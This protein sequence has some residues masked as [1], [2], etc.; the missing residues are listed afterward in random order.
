MRARTKVTTLLS[1]SALLLVGVALSGNR[2]TCIPIE[3]T[4]P[5]TAY[6]TGAGAAFG[7]CWGPCDRELR[8]D[9]A[10]MSFLVRG[11]DNRVFL[12]LSGDLA[13]QLT[14]AG[15]ARAEDLALS[16]LEA[17]LLPR[18]G[19]PDCA[20]GGDCFVS[21]VRE[22]V[23]STHHY[24]CSMGVPDVLRP[25]HDFWQGIMDE[26]A[27][28]EESD[29]LTAPAG[30]DCVPVWE[31]RCEHGGTVYFP[32]DSFPAGD[33]C[34]TCTCNGDGRIYCTEIA[35]Q[36]ASVLTG[37]GAEAGMCWGPCRQH[38]DIEGA[39]MTFTALGW[40]DRVYLEY[41]GDLAP[42]LTALG[43]QRASEIGQALAGVTLQPVYGCPDCADGGDCHVSLLRDGA[44]S[45]HHFDCGGG[46]PD[47][48]GDAHD[49]V[50]GMMW[51]LAMCHESD[52]FTIDADFDCIPL[53]DLTL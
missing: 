7:E 16:L 41:S 10:T 44:A 14:A 53:W 33:G 24:D 35:C 11:W 42:R 46:P 30:W 19:C 45:E 29:F 18:Y 9:G 2:T 43:L 22:G 15:R 38:L 32:G 21:L 4:A 23:A 40:D 12:D 47:V 25:A 20:D 26:L 6:F 37:G 17:D 51:D 13:V 52:L 49:F 3:P 34:N 5:T 48:L 36:P 27:S 28:C 8:I 1:V 31:Q 39:L 50:S